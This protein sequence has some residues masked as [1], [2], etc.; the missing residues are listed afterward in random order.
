MGRPSADA[1]NWLSA[2]QMAQL[3]SLAELMTAERAARS[4]VLV[5]SRMMPSI[6]LAMIAVIYGSNVVFRCHC[7]SS[8][9]HAKQVISEVTYLGA[10]AWIDDQ[11][12]GRLFDDRRADDQIAWKNVA[13][14]EDRS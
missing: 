2:V 9:S 3:K 6:L 14:L 4:S 1:S 13:R 5:I 12:R 7:V 11:G 10:H 8:L